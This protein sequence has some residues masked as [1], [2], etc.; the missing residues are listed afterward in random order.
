MRKMN[1]SPAR[2]RT[3]N[4]AQIGLVHVAKAQLGLSEEEYRALLG[5]FGAESSKDLGP[6]Q[7]EELLKHFRQ[8]GFKQLYRPK[9]RGAPVI[10]RQAKGRQAHLGLIETTLAALGMPWAYAEGIAYKM[11]GVRRLQWLTCEKLCKVQAALVYHG[12]RQV[13]GVRDQEGKK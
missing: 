11:F 8:C 1:T 3:I 13:S 10:S 9:A 5:R 7:L 12:S 6:E 2:P 4:K